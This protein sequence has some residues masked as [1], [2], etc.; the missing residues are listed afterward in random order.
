MP[1]PAR[2]IIAGLP[3]DKRGR[4]GDPEEVFKT[5]PPDEATEIL[6]LSVIKKDGLT[7]S[8]ISIR[9]VKIRD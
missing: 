9:S 1:V 5:I 6:G 2:S 4:Y 3:T 7:V 8:Q